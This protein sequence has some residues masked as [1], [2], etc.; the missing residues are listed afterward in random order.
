MSQAL[1]HCFFKF[2]NNF[3]G[4]LIYDTADKSYV[5]QTEPQYIKSNYMIKRFIPRA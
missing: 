5:K 2:Q 4:C 1:F 3:F